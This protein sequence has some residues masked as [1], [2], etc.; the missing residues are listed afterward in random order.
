MKNVLDLHS[1]KRV[2]IQDDE[3]EFLQEGNSVEGDA[4]FFVE[5]GDP[6]YHSGDQLLDHDDLPSLMSKTRR[7]S[8][9]SSWT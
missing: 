1:K 5:D 7:S 8:H 9:A 3:F 2:E 6:V 4:G